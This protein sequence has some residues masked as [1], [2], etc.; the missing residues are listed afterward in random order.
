MP[1]FCYLVKCNDGS[2]YCGWTTNPVRR[3]AVHNSGRGSCY[4]R[5]H[6]PVTL[7]YQE[8]LT[9]RSSAMRREFQIK[10]L[11]HA[12]KLKLIQGSES[13]QSSKPY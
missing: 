5:L 2:L 10:K 7:V 9:D 3:V 12:Q 11:T 6:R 1:F 13:D 8:I 4:T